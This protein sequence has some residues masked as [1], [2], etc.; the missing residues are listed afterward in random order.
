MKAIVLLLLLVACVPPQ[1]GWGGGRAGGFGGLWVTPQ[2][3]RVELQESGNQVIGTVQAQGVS[4]RLQGYVS[5]TQL[6]GTYQ[7]SSGQ[8]GQF[9]AYT[10]G[11]QLTLQAAGQQIVLQ[12]S[13]GSGAVAGGANYGG[14][15]SAAGAPSPTAVANLAGRWWHTH[16]N[17]SSAVSISRERTLD[18]CSDGT[19]YDS[20]SSMVDAQT[21]TRGQ[22]QDAWG[23]SYDSVTGS[24]YAAGQG[25][26]AGR[27]NA[28]GD[29]AQGRLRLVFNNGT[30]EEHAYVFYKRGGGDI[31]LDGQWF[32]YT[33]EG[34]RCQ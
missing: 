24:G 28:E 5:G 2:G 29:D 23:N 1:G 25:G 33:Q 10:D 18:L 13:N 12:R 17:S 7:L 19:F 30:V 34:R 4:G 27:W 26:G 20:S 16:N 21:T 15:A 11:M 6:S 14:G 3:A 9:S 22:G 31:E 8:S 32:G